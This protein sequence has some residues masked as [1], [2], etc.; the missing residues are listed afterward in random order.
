M[1][2]VT[3]RDLGLLAEGGMA[4]VARAVREPDGLPVVIKRVRPPLCFD[5]AYLR[6]F[7]D[8]AAVHGA[9]DD[10]HVVRLIDRGEDSQ[11]PYLVFEH[12]DGTDL[13]ALLDAALAAE[14]PLDV[15]LVL[16]V[17]V[18]L[19][20]A[21]AFVHEACRD[22]ACLDVVHRDVSPANVL[23]GEDGAV[24]LADF[25]VAS[26]RLKTEQT[27][28]G[29]LKGKFAYMAPEQTRGEQATPQTDLFAVGVVLWECLQNRRLWDRPTDA[30]VV[31]A[32][33]EEPAPALDDERVGGDLAALVAGLLHKDP[34][35]RPPSARVVRDQLRAACLERGLDEGLARVVARAVRLAPRRSLSP[36]PEGRR[37]T[38]R[39]IGE[40][41]ALPVRRSAALGP[42]LAATVALILGGGGA[43][44]LLQ[45]SG[46]PAE[47]LPPPFVAAAPTTLPPTTPP[48]TTPPPTTPPPTLT[49]PT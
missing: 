21:L 7:A 34:L 4:V 48:P 33:R 43:L 41:A 16:A 3:Y 38:Q 11:G 31:R 26:S 18:P 29:E 13:C 1:T 5:S 37:R 42:R 44:T 12:V 17:A 28:A 15:E 25:G 35:Q 10:D 8:E 36:L 46:E 47:P 23:L 9:L 45:A 30:D 14:R 2:S 40:G 32:V 20:S 6:L 27:V 22:G 39:V 24:K 49:A 19:V